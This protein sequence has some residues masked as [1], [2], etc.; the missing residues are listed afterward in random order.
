[1]LAFASPE[2]RARMQEGLEEIRSGKFALE[3]AAERQA[4]Y[5]LLKMLREAARS[6][7]LYEVE[8]ELRQALSGSVED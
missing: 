3:W 4:G 2:L 7:P 5:P 8:H 1:M 6:L